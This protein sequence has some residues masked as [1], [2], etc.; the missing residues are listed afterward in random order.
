MASCSRYVDGVYEIGKEIYEV[1]KG[2]YKVGKGKALG[3]R[4]GLGI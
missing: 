1:G 4:K 3:L 2:N